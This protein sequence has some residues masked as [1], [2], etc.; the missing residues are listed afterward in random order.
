MLNQTS[1]EVPLTPEMIPNLLEECMKASA[2]KGVVFSQEYPDKPV[3]VPTIVWHTK[4]RTPGKENKETKKGRQRGGMQDVNSSTVIEYDV[5]WSTVI[6]QFDLFHTSNMEADRLMNEFESFIL[7]SMI[8][9]I[10]IGVDTFLFYEQLEDYSLPAVLREIPHR[11]LRYQATFSVYRPVYYPRIRQILS[12]VK[13]HCLGECGYAQSV[14]VNRTS[15]D[16]DTVNI[17][18]PAV[19]GITDAEETVEPDYIAGVDYELSPAEDGIQT[20]IIWTRAGKRPETGA[21]YYVSHSEL[22]ALS[23]QTIF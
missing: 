23:Y 16:F 5:Q 20:Q 2:L 4:H 11:S 13:T 18:L 8:S 22:D 15:D 3:K 9:L 14:A 10:H 1:I 6:Y 7:E 17:P 12:Y 21:S 19:L